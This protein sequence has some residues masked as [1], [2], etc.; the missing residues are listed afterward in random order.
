M[1]FRWAA[2]TRPDLIFLETFLSVL[3]QE[4]FKTAEYI[5]GTVVELKGINALREFLTIKFKDY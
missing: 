2:E 3:S 4:Y 5:S 1:R